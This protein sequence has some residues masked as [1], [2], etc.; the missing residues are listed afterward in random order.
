MSK[1]AFLSRDKLVLAGLCLLSA[2]TLKRTTAICIMCTIIR[3]AWSL[4]FVIVHSLISGYW[5][6]LEDT[7]EEMVLFMRAS[8]RTSLHKQGN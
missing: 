8:A 5:P 2:L 6:S 4:G 7:L 1:K 3:L